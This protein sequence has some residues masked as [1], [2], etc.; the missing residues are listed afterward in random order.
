MDKYK[1][2][3]LIISEWNK[4]SHKGLYHILVKQ[5]HK[6]YSYLAHMTIRLKIQS[7]LVLH[8]H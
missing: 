2:M 5:Q 7:P 1:K 8:L 4:L 6:S 3:G